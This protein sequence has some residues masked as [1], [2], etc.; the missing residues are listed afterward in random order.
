MIVVAKKEHEG[1]SSAGLRYAE[2]LE[3]L[4]GTLREEV[5]HKGAEKMMKARSPRQRR[6]NS[7]VGKEGW[8]LHH[9]HTY[10]RE[11]SAR[12]D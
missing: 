12:R 4:C 9:H 2:Q 1:H 7:G 10:P 8:V 5:T 6:R 11:D 3:V